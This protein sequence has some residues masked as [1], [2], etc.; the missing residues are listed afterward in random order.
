M[1]TAST[2]KVVRVKD[3][4]LGAHFM[5]T[6]MSRAPDAVYER[7]REM[8]GRCIIHP[9]YA[10]FLA[11]VGGRPSLYLAGYIAI[12]LHNYDKVGSLEI[13]LSP[14]DAYGKGKIRQT[15]RASFSEFT[16]WSF[17]NGAKRVI[18]G[19]NSM[20]KH[21]DVIGKLLHRW[22]YTR[23]GELYAMEAA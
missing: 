7:V 5:D 10:L 19:H 9:D 15:M 1:G 6:A 18:L 12:E 20:V 13:I 4:N 11:L 2:V 3:A 21:A 17:D 8:V 22:G 23:I 14:R 16:R